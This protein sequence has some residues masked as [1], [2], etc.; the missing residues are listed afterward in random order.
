MKDILVLYHANC[1]DGFTSAWIAWKNF[2]DSAIYIPVKH[3]E[4]PPSEVFENGKTI[5]MLDFFS[6][7]EE[8]IKKILETSKKLIVIDHHISVKE[9]LP[10]ADEHIFDNEESGASLSWKYFFPD[11][12]IPNLVKYVMKGDLWKFESHSTKAV[13]AT[14]SV[15]DF[16]FEIWDRMSEDLEND[17]V[18]N[19]YVESGKLLNKKM[20]K[21]VDK[22]VKDAVWIE[23]D[24]HKC[25]AVNSLF[26]TSMIGHILFKKSGTFGFVWSL[27]GDKII[28]S[29]RS[30]EGG[31]DVSKL[32]KKH[33]GGGHK[34]AAGFSFKENGLL[35]LEKLLN[36]NV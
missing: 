27:R 13:L 12:K 30:E 17:E 23:F 18:R 31:V 3:D 2:G 19:Q 14:I 22:A 24:G 5:Y 34:Y 9:L 33:G 20:M 29:L 16:E 15:E 7:P 28:V 25:L 11:E 26:H 35:Q 4:E 10:L 6:Y 21:E 1:L 32:A 36:N 8:T